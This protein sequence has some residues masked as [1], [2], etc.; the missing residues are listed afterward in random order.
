MISAAVLT[1]PT[2]SVATSNTDKDFECRSQLVRGAVE[3]VLSGGDSRGE[4]NKGAV[5]RWMQRWASYEG[6][7]YL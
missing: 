5:C 1:C 2:P 6:C 4:V 3:R 7:F